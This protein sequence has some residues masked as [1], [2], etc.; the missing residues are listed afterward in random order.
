MFSIDE[1]QY[2]CFA[3][4]KPITHFPVIF[5]HFNI[6]FIKDINNLIFQRTKNFY[7]VPSTIPTSV[8]YERHSD[9][10]VNLFDHYMQIIWKL[11]KIGYY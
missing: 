3:I 9:T 5:S 2:Y 4:T 11:K 1:P 7:I 10:L 8:M 6:H